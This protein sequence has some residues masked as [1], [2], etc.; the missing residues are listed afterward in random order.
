MKERGEKKK[1]MR[2]ISYDGY[3]LEKDVHQHLI[4]AEN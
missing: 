4:V 3:L 2:I 1:R